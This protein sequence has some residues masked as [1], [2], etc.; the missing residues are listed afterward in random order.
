MLK[1]ALLGGVLHGNFS[2]LLPSVPE[3]PPSHR[4]TPLAKISSWIGL[5][6]PLKKCYRCWDTWDL[7]HTSCRSELSYL[8]AC[9]LDKLLWRRTC[10][11]GKIIHKIPLQSFNTL[12][13]TL[14]ARQDANFRQVGKPPTTEYCVDI[15]RWIVGKWA[16]LGGTAMPSQPVS[17]PEQAPE[18]SPLTKISLISKEAHG[19]RIRY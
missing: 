14:K 10:N 19:P 18:L 12:H 9:R 2:V 8:L 7:I 5:H 15:L 6:W 17:K 11:P 1:N 16:D 4:S 3:I 13:Q